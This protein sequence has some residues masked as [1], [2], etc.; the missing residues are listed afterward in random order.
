[1]NRTRLECKVING[2]VIEFCHIHLNR[3]RLECKEEDKKE[4]VAV[5]YDLNRTR[6]ECKANIQ[7]NANNIEII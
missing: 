2:N 7:I 6:L 3:T 5:D 1:M 4:G